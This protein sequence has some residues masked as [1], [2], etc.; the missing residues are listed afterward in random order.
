MGAGD[1]LRKE[2]SVMDAELERRWTSW[3][4][5]EPWEPLDEAEP[6]RTMR[7]VTV[8]PTKVGDVA[9]ERRAAAAAA[10]DR[11]A[12]LSRLRTK[13]FE[14]AREADGLGA[15]CG[16][17]RVARSAVVQK[18]GGGGRSRGA[19]R[20]GR[21]P[22]PTE[23][24]HCGSAIRSVMGGCWAWPCWWAWATRSRIKSRTCKR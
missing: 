3:G 10:L 2:R 9:C 12:L 16:G 6:R 14:A 8:S 19:Y 7:L 13:A 17:C 22:A 24:G 21:S 23:H 11:L 1:E 4:R 18:Q 5:W 15:V 20:I